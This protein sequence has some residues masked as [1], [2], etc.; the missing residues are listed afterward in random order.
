MN[1]CRRSG[2]PLPLS[3]PWGGR[4]RCSSKISKHTCDFGNPVFFPVW[5][6][7]GQSSGRLFRRTVAARLYAL[8]S[9][10]W[11]GFVTCH[12]TAYILARRA[13]PHIGI[14][15]CLL[16]ALLKGIPARHNK[17]GERG[18]GGGYGK[19]GWHSCMESIN[20]IKL[21]ILSFH[22]LPCP[23]ILA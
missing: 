8:S 21:M 6:E 4:Q 20:Y 9:K 5:Q 12:L 7:A 10:M 15:R 19:G 17:R 22:A 23:Y 14:I 2:H 11:V 16:R 13:A 1:Q 18:E 3:P